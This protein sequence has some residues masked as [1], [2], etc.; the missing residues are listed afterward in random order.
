VIAAPAGTED[1]AAEAAARVAPTADVRVVSGGPTRA[2]SVLL[3]TESVETEL[4]AV[5]DAARPLLTPALVDRIVGRL[6]ASPEA[7][8][9]IAAAPVADTLKRA[10][11]G[12]GVTE[13][14]SRVGLWGAQTPQV[15]RSEV[16]RAAQR[17]AVAA[18]DLSSATDEAWLIE[19]IGGIVLLE[20]AGAANLKVTGPEDLAVVE[21]LL[22]ARSA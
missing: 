6:A 7:G 19:R 14:L 11:D 22:A 16:L 15:A 10:E 3:A 2:E 5:H 12:G 17:D 1:A 4:V 9:V 18:G 21:A 13:T 20:P 8:C